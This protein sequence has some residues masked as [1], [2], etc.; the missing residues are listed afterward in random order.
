[1]AI[2]F[3]VR[4][5]IARWQRDGLIDAATA[6]SLRKD[7]NSRSSGFG[8]GGVLALLGAVLLGAAIVSLV[9]ANWEAMPRLFRVRSYYG[10]AFHW[11]CRRSLAGKQW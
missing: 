4:K 2:S 11:L 6:E 3:G 10:G 5:H 8:L 1:M 9:A 7:I